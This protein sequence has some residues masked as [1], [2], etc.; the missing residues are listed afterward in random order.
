ME[1][2]TI[3]ALS[4][5]LRD[6]D[7]ARF[8]VPCRKVLS[9]QDEMSEF[10][11]GL[12]RYRAGGKGGSDRG[13]HLRLHNG[14]PYAVDRVG[15]GAFVVPNWSACFL[16]GIQPEPIQLIA[17]ETADDGLLQRFVYCVPDQQEPGL[18]REPDLHAL[19]RYEA[20]FPALV[21]MQPRAGSDGGDQRRR[22]RCP[23][24]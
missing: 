20:L 12:D 11:S 23:A 24:R 15:R 22:S 10:L 7:A 9:R 19:N 1:G 6:D 5:V 4:E 16:G 3:E 21:A 18:D 8:R 17:R 2:A 14:G 13:A